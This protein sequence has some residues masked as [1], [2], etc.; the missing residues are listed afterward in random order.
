M[1][2]CS[3]HGVPFIEC[4]KAQ[5]EISE[6]GDDYYC[7]GGKFGEEHSCRKSNPLEAL[8]ERVEALE[9]ALEISPDDV[10]RI[11]HESWSKTKRAQG[12][13]G[14]DEP[15]TGPRFGYAVGLAGCSKGARC[16]KFHA[17][18]IPWEDLPESQKDINRHAF[19]AV[20]AEIKRRAGNGEAARKLLDSTAKPSPVP[21]PENPS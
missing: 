1:A 3:C 16:G 4:P 5:T 6:L 8:R 2:V 15:C 10:G 9:K 7:E 11:M 19:D 17:D 13:H 12:F 18:L 14:P 21:G 20:L